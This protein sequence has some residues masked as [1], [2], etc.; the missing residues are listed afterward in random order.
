MPR[1][2]ERPAYLLVHEVFAAKA[3]L[4]DRSAI[5]RRILDG[6]TAP[7]DAGRIF[8]RVKPG[9]AVY[10]HLV[11]FSHDPAISAPTLDE[12][13]SATRTTYAGE[14]EVGEDLMTIEVG[15]RIEVRRWTSSKL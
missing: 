13:V 2:R 9:L 4:L 3:P 6:H 15:E 10:S 8:S 12:L 14:L 5:A 7:E 1:E 11:L